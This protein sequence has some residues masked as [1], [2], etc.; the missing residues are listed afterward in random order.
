[1]WLQEVG[2]D[3]PTVLASENLSEAVVNIHRSPHTGLVLT[4][5]DILPTFTRLIFYTLELSSQLWTCPQSSLLVL[6][7][8]TR[9]CLSKCPVYEESE[10]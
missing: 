1:M 2:E 6:P 10:W 8:L 7:T 9:G 5:L 3:I 4:Q